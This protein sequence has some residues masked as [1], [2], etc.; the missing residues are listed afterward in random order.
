MKGINK[1]CWSEENKLLIKASKKNMKFMVRKNTTK[2][3]LLFGIRSQQLGGLLHLNLHTISPNSPLMISHHRLMSGLLPAHYTYPLGPLSI[4][5]P[6][7]LGADLLLL[8]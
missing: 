1:K 4:L 6:D 3:Y 5:L 7:D 8:Y 2:T